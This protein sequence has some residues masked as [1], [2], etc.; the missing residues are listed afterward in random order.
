MK[1]AMAVKQCNKYLWNKYL[2]LSNVW[3]FLCWIYWFTVKD[4]SFGG[5]KNLFSQSNFK[6]NDRVFLNCL[7]KKIWNGWNNY[8]WN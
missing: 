8:Q 1:H 7:L 3:M 5:F 2:W 4:K 6:N